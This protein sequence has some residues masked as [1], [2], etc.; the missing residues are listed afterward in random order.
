MASF[1]LTLI[2]NSFP[3]Y[4]GHEYYS[5]TDH[6]EHAGCKGIITERNPYLVIAWSAGEIKGHVRTMLYGDYNFENVMAAVC[7][8]LYFG[9]SSA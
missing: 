8:G 1:S 7:I 9:I 4:P 6:A 5:P 2:T 3:A